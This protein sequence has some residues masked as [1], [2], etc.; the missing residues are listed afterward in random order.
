MTASEDITKQ[1]KAALEECARLRE[2]NK[3]LRSLL[4][5]PAEKPKAAVMCSL[6][7]EEKIALFRSLFRGREDVYPVRWEA[8]TGE[9]AGYSPA[10]ANEWKRPLCAKPRVRCSECENREL[11]PVTNDT[12][13]NHLLGKHTIGVYPLLPDETCWFLAVD[14]DKTTWK[15]DA[16]A[17]LK[18]CEELGVPAAH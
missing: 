14:F 1:L 11:V 8:K 18:T 6:S 12:I 2:E 9:K 17:F 13:Q 7:P 4:A 15:E 3:R 10:C 5:L 16:A